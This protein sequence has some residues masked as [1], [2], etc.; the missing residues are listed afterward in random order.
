MRDRLL[1]HRLLRLLL[2]GLLFGLAL[3]GPLP[4]LLDHAAGA[5]LRERNE[6]YLEQSQARAMRSLA[7]LTAV[8]AGLGVV[9]G[10]TV[11]MNLGVSANVQWGDIVQ[12][13]FDIA[14]LAWRT[15]LAGTVGL[16]GMGY[17]LE[18]A[19]GL[20]E[21]LLSVWLG[22]YLLR[23]LCLVPWPEARLAKHTLREVAGAAFLLWMVFAA[24]LPLSVWGASQLS[25]RITQRQLQ[26][27][28]EGY[29]RFQERWFAAEE[30]P[31]EE[32]MKEKIQRLLQHLQNT[33][34]AMKDLS[35]EMANW[36]LHLMAAYLFDCLVFPLAIFMLLLRITKL[37]AN[38]ALQRSL[39]AGLQETPRRLQ[40]PPEA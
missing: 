11:G 5:P 23:A 2:W 27:A 40:A 26:A 25:E 34:S 20:G 38:I 37:I 22:L 33:V 28:E 21:L 10:S 18:M 1:L 17:I 29:S 31:N 35:G 15:V 4:R 3:A 39:L 7:I 12:P 36:T 16:L 19:R 32:K 14:D 30:E 13:A 6:G 24:L 8:K 9:E